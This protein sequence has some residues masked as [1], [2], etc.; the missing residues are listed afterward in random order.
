MKE[1]NSGAKKG[2]RSNINN[3]RID[4]FDFNESWDDGG[5]IL[6]ISTI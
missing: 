2:G 1:W 6:G 3:S 5:D 4:D